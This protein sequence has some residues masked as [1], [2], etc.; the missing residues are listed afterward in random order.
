MNLSGITKTDPA[1]SA[2]SDKVRLG[3]VG[4]G[5]WG[6]ELASAVERSGTA[7]VVACH[8]RTASAREG[9]AERF[10]CRNMTSL[11]ELLVSDDVEGVILATP[12]SVH[13]EQ[14]CEAAAASK[15]VLVEKPFTLTVEQARRAVS[16]V[17]S[18]GTLLMVG[19]QRRRQ[20]A[21]R[22]I[23]QM[24]QNGELGTVL[25]ASSM[26]NVSKGYPVTWRIDETETPLGAMTGLGVH[27][28]D[29]YQYLIGPIVVV[30]ALSR[31]VLADQPLDHATGLLFEFESGAVASLLTSHFLPSAVEVTV[32]GTQAAAFN[33][34]D[35]ARLLVQAKSEVSPHEVEL[36]INDP[37]VDQVVE[38]AAAIREG[39]TIETDGRVGLAVTEVFE[40]AVVSARSGRRVEVAELAS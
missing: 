8:A 15:H 27:M 1:T 6:A 9:F 19:H 2:G 24:I 37:L 33:R 31:S 23:R 30:T 14:I 40:A 13:A 10:G 4:L 34:G 18:A 7:E 5:W 11:Q 25:L 32:H 21:N 17:D 35:G 38:F 39:A 20:A 16:A 26:F 36:K 22:C 3:L 12:H 29:T 28:I